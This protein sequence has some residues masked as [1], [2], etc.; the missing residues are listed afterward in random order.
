M[1]CSIL[2]LVLAVGYAFA[3]D[4]SIY[5]LTPAPLEFG[6]QLEPSFI[7]DQYALEPYSMQYV[8]PDKATLYSMQFAE[9]DPN[10]KFSVYTPEPT[11]TVPEFELEPLNP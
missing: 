5:P 2:V 10:T 11:M 6:T 4:F 9:P 3:E 1:K 8:Y 7:P